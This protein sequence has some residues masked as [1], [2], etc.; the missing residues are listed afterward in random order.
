M[1]GCS[2]FLHLAPLAGRGRIASTD[3]IRVRG[4]RSLDNHS[5]RREAP[6]PNPLPARAGRGSRETSAVSPLPAQ[7]R[8]TNAGG[9]KTAVDGEDLSRDVTRALA[10]Q[11][12][13]RCRQ[14]LFQPIAVERDRVVIVGADFRRVYGLCHRGL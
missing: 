5:S 6:H 2:L 12:E 10:A 14:L 9:V 3:A 13:D 1:S 11:E 4:Y 8:Q 7:R